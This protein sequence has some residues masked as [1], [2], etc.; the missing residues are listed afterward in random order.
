MASNREMILADPKLLDCRICSKPF[1][2]LVYQFCATVHWG[3]QLVMIAAR[4]P[5]DAL[6]VLRPSNWYAAMQLRS[7][8]NLSKFPAKAQYGCHETIFYNRKGEHENKCIYLPCIC[9]INDCTFSTGSSEELGQHVKSNHF[10]A[11]KQFCY[12]LPFEVWCNLSLSS[13]TILQETTE[14][15]VFIIQN[16]IV[17][18]G[19]KITVTCIE[20]ASLQ[21]K[22]LYELGYTSKLGGCLKLKAFM[23]R[24]KGLEEA[25]AHSNS[26]IDFLLIP[27]NSSRFRDKFMLEVCIH[28]CIVKTEVNTDA[29]LAG[30]DPDL[31]K[32][33]PSEAGHK[34]R[35]SERVRSAP[36]K[37]RE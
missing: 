36:L 20:S 1:S 23:E 31:N 18:Y 2:A 35:K 15:H 16:I 6:T 33:G 10:T 28:R 3:I 7:S 21:G 29:D 5:K 22:F 34:L 14:G 4:S 13:H 12:R 27:N 25:I 9:P 32:I 8:W 37:L 24:V 19:N 26:S 17:D 11:T 30:V